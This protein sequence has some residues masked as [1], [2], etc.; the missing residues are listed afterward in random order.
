[1]KHTPEFVSEVSFL[2]LAANDDLRHALRNG[3]GH[4]L[5][6]R[7]A[8]HRIETALGMLG[9]VLCKIEGRG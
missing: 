8:M 2:L 4:A 1:M 6:I 3:A 7:N 9:G 5:T